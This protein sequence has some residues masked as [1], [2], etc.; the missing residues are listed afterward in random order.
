MY[1]CIYIYIYIYIY[2]ERERERERHIYIYIYIYIY[3][4]NGPG[5]QLHAVDRAVQ[6]WEPEDLG[7]DVMYI[8]IYTHYI[9]R[10]G[11]LM[12]WAGVH[13]KKPLRPVSLLLLL[14]LIIMIIIILIIVIIIIIINNILSIL[15]LSIIP[16][17]TC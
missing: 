8:Y 10:F 11:S 13:R 12:T 1:I 17:K 15:I 6:A 3:I 14:L 5:R 9:Y 16:T 4:P 2:I 7:G